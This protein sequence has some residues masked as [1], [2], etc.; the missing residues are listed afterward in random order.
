MPYWARLGALVAGGLGIVL[1]LI[2]EFAP[3][4]WHLTILQTWA[5]AAWL[6][7]LQRASALLYNYRNASWR[8]QEHPEFLFLRYDP[9]GKVIEWNTTRWPLPAVAPT[10]A[11]T[12]GEFLTDGGLRYYALKLMT[13]SSL[14]VVLLPIQ[15]RFPVR[16]IYPRWVFPVWGDSEWIASLRPQEAA[17]G[18]PIILRGLAGEPLLRLYLHFPQALRWPFRPFYL[19]LIGLALLLGLFWIWVA[20]RQAFPPLKARLLFLLVLVAVWQISHWS[21]IPAKLL[22]GPLFEAQLFALGPLHNTLWDL[23]WSIGILFW[24][25][26]LLPQG[27]VFGPVF[28]PLAYCG[29]WGLVGG[30]IFLLSRHSQIQLDPLRAFQWSKLVGWG[31]GL[32]LLWRVWQFLEATC[33]RN[34]YLGL[35][36]LGVGGAAALGLSEEGLLAL[37][38]LY[39]TP[40]WRNKLPEYLHQTLQGLLLVMALNSWITWGSQ[41]KARWILAAYAPRLAE[42]RNPAFEYQ[43]GQLLAHIAG[44]T[45]F[46]NR[47]PASLDDNLI[48]ERFLA[49]LVQRY[50]LSVGDQYELVIS[51]WTLEERRA[52]NAFETRPLPWRH[53][54]RMAIPT[55]TPHLYFVEKGWPR[56]FYIVRLPL[57]P[58]GMVPFILQIEFYPRPMPLRRRL[59]AESEDFPLT[60]ALYENGRLIRWW[61]DAPFPTYLYDKQFTSPLWRLRGGHYEYLLPHGRRFLLYMRYPI[62]DRVQAL[63]GLPLLLFLLAIAVG[64]QRAAIFVPYLRS[65]YRREGPIAQQLRAAFGIVIAL[66]LFGLFFATL[67]LFLR[68]NQEQ[69]RRDLLQRLNSLSRYLASDRI[70][71][72][73]LASW[74]PSYVAVEESFVRDLMQRG[75][76]LASAEFCLYSREGYLYAS[77]L[78]RAYL[79]VYVP[80]LLPPKV[81]AHIRRTLD[82][83]IAEEAFI[84]EASQE[85]ALL[86]YMPLRAESGRVIGVLL[87]PLPFSRSDFYKALS[88]FVAY[89]VN[90]YLVLAVGSILLGLVLIQRFS[91]GLEKVVAQ[92]R[93]IPQ[94]GSPPTLHW[95]GKGDE[96]ATLVAV[97]NTMVE[98]LR[99]SQ[100]ELESTLRRVSQQEMAFQA[101]HEIKT[102]LTPLKLQ[103]QHLQRLPA[104]ETDKLHEIATRLL[105]RVDALVRIANAFMS[106]AR[107]GS[108]EELPLRPM[109]LTA[110]L[111]EQIQPYLHGPFPIHLHLP[112]EPLWIL[113]N[114]DA[115]HQI[116][117]NL[118]Q[119]ALQALEDQPAPQLQVTLL[120]QDGKVVIAVQD[121]GPGIPPEVQ[122]RIFEF[123]FTTRRTGTGLG[124]AITRGLVER[125]GGEISFESA[126]GRGTTFYVAFPAY[127]G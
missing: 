101:A 124:L 54:Q 126:P 93:T 14:Q 104:I 106:F 60:Y 12:A 51:C 9:T 111:R 109:L 29:L 83:S 115:L 71:S 24:A 120:K 98:Q 23:L 68:L 125:M 67:F 27:Q 78:P 103:L 37:A 1:G 28:Y 3:L 43:L 48:D 116:L 100:R 102:A 95:E 72:E 45:L 76:N 85:N 55:L 75:A 33:Q 2:N 84:E 41:W 73:K 87:V 77:T 53:L 17:G 119:N 47:L 82:D 123:Y 44:D 35:G 66:P 26:T 69:V 18:L 6:E 19:T 81:L 16:S 80:F 94:G 61:A 70:L 10:F 40:I 39:L 105:N 31:V 86:G 74:L 4:R 96:I 65:F 49:Q 13:D 90:V 107:L 88:Y 22:R 113:A 114:P 91:W 121:N 42:L 15:I 110:F 62:R 30:A 11:S 7:R 89:T 99:K 92:L 56:Y 8:W 58:A 63:A 36:L 59:Y 64:I 50:L 108:A 5:Q 25:T 32:A 20:L 79:G 122:E 117:N 57:H 34:W 97:Y 52:D 127:K 118:L 38:L 46:W 112:E 21:G